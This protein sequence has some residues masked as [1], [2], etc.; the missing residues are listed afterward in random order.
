MKGRTF[1]ATAVGLAVSFVCV[2]LFEMIGMKIF[3]APS[4]PKPQNI[5]EWE[6]IMATFPIGAFIMVALGHGTGVFLG[7][8][9]A[10]RIDRSSI[11]G[12]LVIFLLMFVT[13]VG[14][15]LAYPHPTWFRITDICFVL[16][17]GFAAWRALKWQ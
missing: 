12:F 2:F 14:N 9:I 1:L 6:A 13:T 11:I 3:P 5:E 7:G 17:G 15:V 16:L 4:H 8:L 10:N